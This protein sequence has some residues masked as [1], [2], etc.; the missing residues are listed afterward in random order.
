[1]T[2]IADNIAELVGNTPIVALH[3]YENQIGFDGRILAK[4]EYFNPTGS[5]KD[6]I[7][8][9]MIEA[10]EAEGRLKPDRK[11]GQTQKGILTS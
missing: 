2:K 1:M 6:R 11:S 9:E 10:A 5:V 4:L 3:K 8:K 7:A